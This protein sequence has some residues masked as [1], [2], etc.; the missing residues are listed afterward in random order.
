MNI[1]DI[2][3]ATDLR[4]P[5]DY[6]TKTQIDTVISDIDERIDNLWLMTVAAHVLCMQLGFIMLETGTLSAK[7]TRSI[8]YKNLIDTFVAA[9]VYYFIGY[10][11]AHGG[12]ASGL[13]GSGSYF[14]A[15][16][17]DQDYRQWVIGYCFC[18]TACT[19]VCGSLAE[20]TFI[21]TYLFFTVLMSSL[22]YPVISFWVWGGGWL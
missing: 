5:S 19:A 20:R 13:I 1:T 4:A 9:I 18:S 22:I 15:G 21:D 8:I 7:N 6:L 16:F 17:T 3:L 14:D 12:Q 11:Y 2:S 10:R